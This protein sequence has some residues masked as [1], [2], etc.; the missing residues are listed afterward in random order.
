MACS[1]ALSIQPV[2]CAARD[3]GFLDTSTVCASCCAYAE[4]SRGRL[5]CRWL[6]SRS[7]VAMTH[8]RLR[9]HTMHRDQQ[10]EQE[11]GLAKCN[12]VLTLTTCLLHFV[13]PASCSL[14]P[15]CLKLLK[16]SICCRLSFLCRL[17][18]VL[19]SLF[20]FCPYLPTFHAGSS[21]PFHFSSYFDWFFAIF[22]AAPIFID[23]CFPSFAYSFPVRVSVRFVCAVFVGLFEVLHGLPSYFAQFHSPSVAMRAVLATLRRASTPLRSAWDLWW[24]PDFPEHL[25]VKSFVFEV[26]PKQGKIPGRR[27]RSLH[28]SSGVWCGIILTRK[29]HRVWRRGD[30]AKVSSRPSFRDRHHPH[31]CIE[32]APKRG[33]HHTVGA[34]IQNQSFAQCQN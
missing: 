12:S 6:G 14:S 15:N 5:R 27:L 23:T 9:L 24:V 34:S 7:G 22:F 1:A 4:S 20:V 8:V 16:W 13:V 18:T 28:L 19:D 26:V 25:Q 17:C 32:R 30:D 11:V 10:L 21:V 31:F 2:V 29:G 33:H 3:S